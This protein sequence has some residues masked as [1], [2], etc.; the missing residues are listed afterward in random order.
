MFTSSPYDA[1]AMHQ[2][3]S[4]SLSRPLLSDVA[5][6]GD[7]IVLVP[8]TLTGWVSWAAHADRL[9]A[10]RKVI[11]VQLRNVELTEAS[12]PMPGTYSVE[13]EA[14]GLLRAADELSLDRFDL[15]GWSLGGL[16]SLAFALRF[17]DR[18]RT[19]TLIE[20]AA[21]WVLRASG[22]TDGW[23]DDLEAR[24]REL[25]GKDVSID[26][27]KTFLSRAGVGPDDADLETHPRWP[28]MVRNRQVLSFVGT[29]W[30][31]ADSIDELRAMRIPLL[32]VMG[33]ASPYDVRLVAQIIARTAPNAT[34]LELPGDHTCHIRHMDSF[35]QALDRHLQR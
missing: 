9:A 12:I 34:V 6:H 13:T 29:V 30:D 27:L 33:T 15:V 20:P 14:E 1:A 35:L 19:L 3:G 10:D 18:V 32:V 8:G 24:D 17:P 7:P 23:L 26:D 31:Y 11:R 22:I 28:L 25:T 2:A 5:G 21:T 4:T 16:V